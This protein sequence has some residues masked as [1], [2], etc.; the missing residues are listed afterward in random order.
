MGPSPLCYTTSHKDIGPLVLEKKIFEGFLQ[1]MGLAAILVM[2][3]RPREQLSFPKCIKIR[4]YWILLKAVIIVAILLRRIEKKW[5]LSHLMTKMTN[6]T[7]W[8]MRPANTQISLGIRPVWSEFTVRMNLGSLATHWV[9]SEDWSDW[10]DAQADL[11]LRW[12]HRSFCW[13]CHEAAHFVISYLHFNC[14]SFM[15]KF[16]KLPLAWYNLD[17]MCPDS[18]KLFIQWRGR[19]QHLE[20]GRWENVPSDERKCQLCT[21]TDIG[22]EFHYLLCCKFFES[23]SWSLTFVQDLTCWNLKI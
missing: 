20:T 14:S 10:A 23:I 7:K 6:P 2:W 17:E 22:D 13:F 8:H 9:Y 5:H 3:P 21:K 18:S 4:P 11:S 12:A 1:Y 15:T 16:H 19:H